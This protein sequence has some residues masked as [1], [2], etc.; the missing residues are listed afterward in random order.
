MGRASLVDDAFML[1]RSKLDEDTG[2]WNW[3]KCVQSN[4]YG[5]VRHDGR[6]A[7]AHRL[8]YLM[9]VGEIPDGFDVCHT[10]DNR[11]CVNPDH[12]FVGTRKDNMQDAVSKGRQASG[13]VLPQTKLRGDAAM[14]ALEQ[15]HKGRLYADIAKDFGVTRTSIGRLARNNGVY[16]YGK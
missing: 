1:S 8:S 7:Y 9:L 14:R 12:L 5:R 16:R 6:T 3:S 15:I 13:D 2:C 4:G 11:R 10:C